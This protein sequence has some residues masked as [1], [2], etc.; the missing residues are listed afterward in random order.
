MSRALKDEIRTAPTGEALRRL[1]DEQVHLITSLPLDAAER[2]HEIATKQLYSG[3][4]ADVLAKQI[5]RSGDVSKSRANLIA[6][7]EVARAAS[8]LVQAR[9]TH[10]GSEGY[11]WRTANDRDVRKSH[12][13]MSGKFVRW[14]SP[15]VL[16]KMRG[17]AGQ[18]P[19]CRCY[20]EPVVPDFKDIN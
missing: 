17:H 10:V 8:G 2:V 4:R 13:G 18:F 9:A 16:D 7:T 11:V 14:D 12:K 5:L 19:N 15:P 20:P 3:D 1:L 6:R